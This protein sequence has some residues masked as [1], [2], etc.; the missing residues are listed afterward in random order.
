MARWQS[1][2]TCI[3]LLED[4]EGLWRTLKISFYLLRVEGHARTPKYNL[5]LNIHRQE[6]VESHQKKIPHIQGQ[7]KSP[8]KMVGG[9]KSHLESNP[10]PA[11]DA[12]RAQTKPCAHQDPEAPQ[13]LSQTC[14]WVSCGGMGQLILI[15]LHL[16]SNMWVVAL[17]SLIG[18]ARQILLKSVKYQKDWDQTV[19]T[20]WFRKRVIT[21]W[22]GEFKDFKSCS[23]GETWASP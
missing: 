15:S 17:I 6:N 10:I 13:R 4:S 23:R 5:L 14:I 12:W 19:E 7:R 21:F 9:V 22:A 18:E 3:H 16:N 20:W 1:R 2:R 8:S 11:R